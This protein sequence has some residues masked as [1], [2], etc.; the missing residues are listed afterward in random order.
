MVPGHSCG[1]SA[2]VQRR[3]HTRVRLRLP[4]RLRWVAPLGQ[5]TE[6]CET[7]NASRGGLLLACHE[8]HPIGLPLWVT[9]PFDPAVPDAQPELLARVLRCE[10]HREGGQQVVEVAVHFE[11]SLHGSIG[12][13]APKQPSTAP[14][15]CW[16]SLAIPI[17][18][19]QQNIPWFEEAMST[20]VSLEGLRFISHREY[21]TGEALLVT[22]PSR[23]S[24]PWDGG[25][26]HAARV[27]QVERIPGSS[28]LSVT[29]R[30][31]S[32]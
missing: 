16:R 3:Q 5:Q 4:V 20:D 19:R 9:F 8:E 23:D 6:Q 11:S 22:F 2:A 24:V 13:S 30:K 14:E 17:Q 29:A 31:V 21:S 27:V 26:E 10:D 32:T 12:K 7:R 1:S 15:E 18:V 28:S 25:G